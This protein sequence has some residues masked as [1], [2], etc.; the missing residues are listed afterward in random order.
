MSPKE[1]VNR[2]IL[3]QINVCGKNY[4]YFSIKYLENFYETDLSRLP[5]S[6][7]VL[8]ENLLRF[9]DGNTVSDSHLKSLVDWLK[10]GRSDQEIAFRP[11]RVLMQD[12]TGVPAVVDL[13]AMR[14]REKST[15]PITGGLKW[16]NCGSGF[17]FP[18]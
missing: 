8:L 1:S 16:P 11:A 2:D 14:H 3:G 4:N 5:F 9:R 18:R 7:K 17:R 10:T 15:W 13:A 12:F 6:L